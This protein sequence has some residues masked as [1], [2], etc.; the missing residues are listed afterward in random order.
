MELIQARGLLGEGEGIGQ[1]MV[2]GGVSVA[3]PAGQSFV[4]PDV[5]AM[6]A[7]HSTFSLQWCTRFLV[8]GGGGAF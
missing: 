1:R 3:S 6:L 4:V 5:Q 7:W 8:D 2:V